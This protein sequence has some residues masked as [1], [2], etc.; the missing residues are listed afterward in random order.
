[1]KSNVLCCLFLMTLF[2]ACKDKQAINKEVVQAPNK[3][4]NDA[5]APTKK[6]KKTILCFG[7]SLTA[8][9]G[10]DEDSAWPSLLQDTLDRLGKE[11]VVVNAGLSGETT[12]GGVNRIDWVLSQPVDIFI[13]ELGA[14]DMLRGLDVEMTQTNLEDIADRVKSKY[15]EAKIVIAGMLAPPS[16]G[17]KYVN[18]FNGIFPKLSKKYNGHLIPFFLE[19]VAGIKSLNL[20][21]DKHPN[22][23]GQK[24]VLQNVLNVLLDII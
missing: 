7:D 19:D 20:P 4:M 1:M 3:Q 16:M 5:K 2:S 13:L 14:N 11:Y 10:L 17:D 21:D 9:Y 18:A 22:R 23:E 12:S 24:V 6:A 15:P 8:G